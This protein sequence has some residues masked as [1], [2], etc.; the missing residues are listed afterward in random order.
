M[1][2]PGEFWGSRFMY[3]SAFERCLFHWSNYDIDQYISALIRAGAQARVFVGYIAE[4]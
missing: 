1:E 4:D 3:H 2:G